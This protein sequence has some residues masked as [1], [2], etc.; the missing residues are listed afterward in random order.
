MVPNFSRHIIHIDNNSV[1]LQSAF[2]MYV[3]VFMNMS[4][5]VNMVV[6]FKPVR[7]YVQRS[8]FHLNKPPLLCQGSTW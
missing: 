2:H 3:Q 6:L 4:R 1:I 8:S 5:S 7:S